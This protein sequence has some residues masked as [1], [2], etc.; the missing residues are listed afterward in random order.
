MIRTRILGLAEIGPRC[1]L[2]RCFLLIGVAASYDKLSE[3]IG[4]QQTNKETSQVHFNKIFP[5]FLLIGVSASYDKKVEKVKWT[6]VVGVHFNQIPHLLAC[7][8]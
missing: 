1:I 4:K 5:T 3:K 6:R 7:D 2:T 8:W